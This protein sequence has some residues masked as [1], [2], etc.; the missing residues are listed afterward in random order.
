MITH[1][2]WSEFLNK[3][4][5]DAEKIVSIQ[6]GR[7]KKTSPYWNSRIDEASIR[8]DVIITAMQKVFKSYDPSKE[9]ELIPEMNPNNDRKLR[10][11]IFTVIHNEIS[12]IV[13]KEYEY[14]KQFKELSIEEES[15]FSIGETIAAIPDYSMEQLKSKL[16]SA[17][18]K[19]EPMDQAILGFYLND[20]KSYIEKSV[21]MFNIEPNLVSVHKTR[22]LKKIPELMGVTSRE[23][24]DMY[25]T[26][27]SSGTT[28]GFIMVRTA[29]PE[30]YNFVYP[31]FNL[32]DTVSKLAEI[33][34]SAKRASK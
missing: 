25:E 5:D 3:Y 12:D 22:A 34:Y 7:I 8:Q 29:E 2:T 32:N 15:S 27:H 23:Y 33:I 13:K 14:I 6:L 26:S 20:K 9:N 17:I 11:L 10:N 24:F 16:R 4:L 18:R 30:Q 19:L 28:F 31:D 1:L 21:D